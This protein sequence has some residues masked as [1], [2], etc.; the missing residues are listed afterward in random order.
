MADGL[1]AH[2]PLRVEADLVIEE[3]IS[4]ILQIHQSHLGKGEDQFAIVIHWGNP[5]RFGVKSLERLRWL[6]ENNWRTTFWKDLG[7]RAETYDPTRHINVGYISGDG[8]SLTKLQA[9]VEV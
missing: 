1:V 3:Y 7:D 8:L 4:E 6:E 2:Y 9:I 5:I